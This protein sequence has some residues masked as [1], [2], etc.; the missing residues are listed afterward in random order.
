[1][2]FLVRKAATASSATRRFYSASH[3]SAPASGLRINADRLQETIH[4]T[5]QWGAAHR[6]GRFVL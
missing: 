5:C 1:M 2:P 4:H 3:I 6:Y